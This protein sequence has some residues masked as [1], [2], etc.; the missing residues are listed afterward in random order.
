MHFIPKS[1]SPWIFLGGVGLSI[2]SAEYLV[3]FILSKLP[4]LP[5]DHIEALVDSFLLSIFVAP[6][7]YLFIYKP[8]KKENQ[9]RKRIEKALR[10]STEQL[11]QVNETLEQKVNERTQ[12]LKDKNLQLQSLLEELQS[13]QRQIIQSEKMSSLGQLVAGVAHEINNPVNFIHGNLDYMSQHIQDLIMVLELYQQNTPNPTPEIEAAIQAVDLEFLQT[14]LPNLLRSIKI[15]TDRIC[16]I[17][18]SLRNFSRLDESESKLVNLQ[19]GIKSTLLI[20]G[21]RVRASSTHPEIIISQDYGELPLVE[22]YPGPLNQVFMNLL[23]NAIDAIEETTLGRSYQDIEANPGHIKI[24]ATMLNPQWIQISLADNGVGIPNE[25]QT[26]IFDP[27]FTTKPIGKGTGMGMAITYQI[28]TEK[29]GGS[30]ECISSPG[31]GT[32]FKI[33]LPL[34]QNKLG[35]K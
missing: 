21:H 18:R 19:D 9:D 5:N 32:E 17:V 16:E 10:R 12:E 35:T 2:F 25:I 20:L 3:M 6:A 7:L 11:Q 22:C 26:K 33:Q 28:I 1:R 31:K 4:K 29:H 14:D 8:L 34:F 23:V 30:L 24:S 15:G 27:F 13:T